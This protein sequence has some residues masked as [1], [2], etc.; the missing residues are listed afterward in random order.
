LHFAGVGVLGKAR[1][2]P[3][4]TVRTFHSILAAPEV[5]HE[6]ALNRCVHAGLRE[7]LLKLNSISPKGCLSADANT[8][9]VVSTT[10]RRI[11]AD[12][13]VCSKSK[14]RQTHH[15]LDAPLLGR[16]DQGPVENTMTL[17]PTVCELIDQLKDPDD[18]VRLR[19]VA[20]IAVMGPEAV[21]ALPDLIQAVDD[22]NADIRQVAVVA[23]GEIG[24]PA[25]LA[26]SVLIK[27]LQDSDAVLRKRAAVTLGELGHDAL[28]AVFQL[29]VA[30]RDKD[31]LV[32]RWAAFALGEVGP[33]AWPALPALT[34]LLKHE[35]I[36]NRVVAAAAIKK[37]E[38]HRGAEGGGVSPRVLL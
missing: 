7:W 24:P 21:D 20:T 13:E 37:I 29:I 27:A 33:D 31:D 28:P 4:A 34:E 12:H 32:R 11:R 10:D 38:P 6:V 30:L 19:A 26:I 36:K 9:P 25:K 16:V 22:G 15:P 14:S 5:N 1:Q 35:D 23:L 2:R 3:L 8:V 18:T 17:E